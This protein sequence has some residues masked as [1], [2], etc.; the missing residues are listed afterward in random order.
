MRLAGH[1]ENMAEKFRVVVGKAERERERERLLEGIGIDGRIILKRILN[2][3][4]SRE[5]DSCG[6]L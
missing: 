1:V 5:L 4:G 3:T 2:G 6:S